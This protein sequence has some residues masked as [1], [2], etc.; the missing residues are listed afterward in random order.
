MFA[1]Q[2]NT[3][4]LNLLKDYQEIADRLE[5]LEKQIRTLYDSLPH[6]SLSAIE[7]ARSIE[8]Y[9]RI[10]KDLQQPQERMA[11]VGENIQY[12]HQAR[13][14][15]MQAQSLQQRLENAPADIAMPFVNALQAWSL[16]VTSELSSVKL[17]GLKREPQW[18]EQFESIEREFTQQLKEEEVRFI[19][20]Q[21]NY[22]AF[23]HHAFPYV[24]IW[25]DI[26]FNATQ[27]QDSYKRLW[28][29]VH[30]FLQ[31]AVKEAHTQ[32]Q[33]VH[34]RVMRLLSGLDNLP[35]SERSATHTRLT[36]L[37]AEIGKYIETT[38]KWVE[39]VSS[40]D[41]IEPVVKR[42]TTEAAETVL[43]NVVANITKLTEHIPEVHTLII[44]DEQRVLAAKLSTEEIAMM[45][46][47]REVAREGDGIDGVELGLLFQRLRGS[48][49]ANW[50][51]LA[52]LYSKQRL[53]V[54]VAPTEYE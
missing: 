40:P 32:V 43:H 21:E 49:T 53:S 50:Q 1:D 54:K 29:G 44:A 33:S 17:G 23:L 19:S 7:V 31:E 48:Q 12:Y 15:L 2:L 4:R 51:S 14:L 35:Q 16:Q 13:Q 3:Q 52:S 46:L 39:S 27:P 41:F 36:G 42:G 18:R 37:L 11:Q 9:K 47:L 34:D 8:Q 5:K 38:K 22:Q 10:Q 25:P 20:I 24:R 28:E 45:A 30:T 6:V 26:V